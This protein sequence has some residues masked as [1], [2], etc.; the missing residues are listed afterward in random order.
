M[1]KSPIVQAVAIDGLFFAVWAKIKRATGTKR[2]ALVPVG[3]GLALVM[4]F[5]NGV[6]TLQ[7][8]EVLTSTVA[9]QRLHIDPSLFTFLRAASV[10]LVAI[11]VSLVS[12]QGTPQAQPAGRG[13][14]ANP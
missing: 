13:H 4:F 7:Q 8:V 9:M 14:P 3:L 2:L 10:I 12:G 11:L 6:L 1:G 5:I